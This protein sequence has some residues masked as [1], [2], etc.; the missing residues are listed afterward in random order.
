M[1][2]CLRWTL[3]V[4]F[5]GGPVAAAQVEP[6]IEA[7]RLKLSEDWHN[8]PAPPITPYSGP[9]GDEGRA[10]VGK[11]G[12]GSKDPKESEQLVKAFFDWKRQGTY[13]PDK[14][15]RAINLEFERATLEDWRRMGYNCSYKGGAFT[16]RVGRFLKKNGMLG[17][18]DQTLWAARGE[19]ALSHDGKPGNR[20]AEGSGSFLAK[21]TWDA[22][23]T[24][25]TDYATRFG[26]PDMCRVGKTYITCSWD[27]IGMRE[28]SMIDYRPEAVAEYRK[29]LR[30][31][32][33]RD[34]SPDKDTNSDGVTYNAFTG[35]KLKSWDEVQP[36]RLAPKYYESP[37]PGDEKWA[38]PGAFKLWID[39]HRY[40]T[41]EY[42]RRT[43]EAVS[44]RLGEGRRIECYPF[45]IAF[46]MWP[47]ANACWGLSVYWNARLNPIL[48]VE[49]CWPDGPAMPLNYAMYDRLA[50]RYRNVVIGWSWFFF[51]K[52]ARDFYEGPN[53][54]GRALARM[55]GQRVDGIH[56]WLYSPIYR[57]RDQR[58]RLQLAYWH[59]FLARHYST[60]LSR[61][62]PL[63]PEAAVLMPDYTGYFYRMFNHPKADFAY[64][65]QGLQEA[66][67]AY[68]VVTEEELELDA[69]AL[70]PY[71]VLY[72]TSSEWTTPAIR[73]R[74]E[75][76]VGRGGFVCADVDSLSLDIP[77]G[78]RTD[79]LEKTFGVK[80]E[81][82]HKNGFVPSAQNAEE[83]AWGAALTGWGKPFWLQ[84]NEV[85]KPGACAKLWKFDGGKFVRDE[86]VWKK[87][88][89]AMAK[90]PK[91]VR[92]IPQTALDMR[93]PPKVRYADGVGPKDPIVT[94]SEV[95]TATA[96]RGKAIA[97]FGDKVC[98]VETERTVWLGTR[99]GMDLH[100]TAPR[101]SLSRMTEPCNPFVTQVSPLYATHKP[102]VDVISYA[103]RKAG[104]KRVV[105]LSVKGE[106]P[107]NLEVLPRADAEG[108][109]L[110]IVVNQDSTDATYQVA[111]NPEYAATRLP[112]GALAWNLLENK[113]IEKDTRGAFDLAVP[114]EKVAVFFIGAE[115]VLEPVRKAQAELNAADLS[116]PKYFR[117]R[118]A[119][120]EGE[121]GTA[122]PA[123]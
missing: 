52:E 102:N 21:E 46:I 121:Y 59:N 7:W 23:L 51:G 109:L 75:D 29:Y 117:D 12:S 55:M 16:Y 14:D 60:F 100:A 68:D 20:Y 5:L 4:A 25:L 38:R 103:A 58:Q 10:F 70:K 113:L 108:N 110:V 26:D 89:E 19:P 61:S 87:L 85:H 92:G 71:K 1:A 36:P 50:R 3:L 84:G 76:F 112:K 33:F 28:R 116:V 40:Y 69:D 118:P 27:E 79:F 73:K 97:W 90:M 88:D 74:I 107:C 119:L 63:V 93:D 64:T 57:G 53:D 111:V 115:K 48:N 30:E 91:E 98:G 123:E 83:E 99:A 44:A 105:S 80:I 41:F 62:A 39:F 56:H 22:G 66:Q 82:K 9:F 17:A 78:A 77:T 11:V 94:W 15:P 67:I 104:V 114:P 54:I 31:V 2:G 106:I 95:D 96:V 24:Y 81:C 35:E 32:W 120:N 101:L 45:P 65:A 72:V 18:I 34:E 6:P 13:D 47:G 86:D 8:L 37:A 43:N 42:F 49:Q 122:V